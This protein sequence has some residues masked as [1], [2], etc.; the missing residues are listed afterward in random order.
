[1]LRKRVI[2]TLLVKDGSLVKTRHFKN[3]VYVG[4]PCNTARI[5]NEFEVDELIVLDIGT[6]QVEEAINYRLLDELASECFMP[7]GYGGRITSIDQAARIFDLGYEKISVNTAAL[8]N[9]ELISDLARKFG[10]QAVVISIDVNKDLFGHPQV[11]WKG[12]RGKYQQTPI[13]WASK[14]CELGAGEVLFTSVDREGSWQGLDLELLKSLVANVS[15][16]VIAHGGAGCNAHIRQ[17]FDLGV[18]AV[19]LGSMVVFQKQGSG[20]LVHYEGNLLHD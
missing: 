4:D 17:A 20:V 12:H 10:T 5:F 6:G 11:R 9:P 1:M 7:L 15:V 18:D 16:P 2:P 3:P 14:A 19:A 8:E 13:E